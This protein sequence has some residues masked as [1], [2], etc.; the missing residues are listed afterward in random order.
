MD[1]FALL[2]QLRADYPKMSAGAL[3]FGGIGLGWA[4]GWLF[5]KQ[6]LTHHKEMVDHY[7]DVIG[8]K[9]GLLESRTAVAATTVEKPKVSDSSK[10]NPPPLH[11]QGFIQVT[12][13][14]LM[15][16]YEGRTQ[17]Q[18]DMLSK[19]YINE[20]IIVKCHVQDVIIDSDSAIVAAKFEGANLIIARFARENED[21]VRHLSPGEP[22]TI[23]GRI[24]SIN[25]LMLTLRECQIADGDESAA[26]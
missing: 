20:R 15:D 22:I 2:D 8:G 23:A 12:P 18:G 13:K 5:F 25:S 16:L 14:Y 4:I 9:F 6:R 10:V 24:H 26:K 17:L 1:P 7:K 11:K 3:V 19:G 21:S